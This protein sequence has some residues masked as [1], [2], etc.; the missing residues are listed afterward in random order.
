MGRP[1]P[2]L[3]RL[4]PLRRQPRQKVRGPREPRA[5]QP[6]RRQVGQPQQLGGAIQDQPEAD[7]REAQSPPPRRGG[8]RPRQG[9]TEAEEE[10]GR[11]R[12]PDRG[13][14]GR[15]AQVRQEGRQ[16]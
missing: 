11:G 5:R 1:R 7:Q 16:R 9:G 6:G 15:R 8:S 12:R 4:H 2:P 13:P 10:A 3:R 14:A